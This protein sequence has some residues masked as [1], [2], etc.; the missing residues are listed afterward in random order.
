MELDTQH[1]GEAQ[2]CLVKGEGTLAGTVSGGLAIS[3]VLSA[4]VT[5]AS[6][7]LIRLVVQLGLATAPVPKTCAS[8]SAISLLKLV[9]QLGL[10]IPPIAYD[11]KQQYGVF[12]VKRVD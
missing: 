3:P 2:A 10:A 7:I 9:T 12:G 8:T 6:P 4:Y 5:R 11:S 1:V